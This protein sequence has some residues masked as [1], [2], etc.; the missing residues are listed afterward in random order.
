MLIDWNDDQQM[1]DFFRDNLRVDGM[2][3][4]RDTMCWLVVRYESHLTNFLAMI[5]LGC[6]VIL[7][8]RVLG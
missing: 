5:Q 2:M 7:L 4:S 6:V 8:R 1:V 3:Y